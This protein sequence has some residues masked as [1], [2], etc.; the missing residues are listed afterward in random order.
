MRSL[1]GRAHAMTFPSHGPAFLFCPGDR[2]DR[3]EKALAAADVVILD[4][5]DAVAPDHKDA[6]RVEVAS[7]ARR[8]GE[9]AV[10]RVNGVGTPWHTHDVTAMHEAGVACL[11]LP[12]VSGPEDL[13]GL[14]DVDVIALCETAAG[15]V[16]ADRIA[17]SEHC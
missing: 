13:F 1:C 11:M 9:R 15:V 12:K 2:P 7:A 10:V 16:R 4:L 8:F 6:G 3:F 17:E 5:E 14:G